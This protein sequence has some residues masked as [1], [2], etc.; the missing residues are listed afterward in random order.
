[1]Q[2]K[3]IHF[4]NSRNSASYRKRKFS[5]DCTPLLC[6]LPIN[7][8]FAFR[9]GEMR[10]F[11]IF[12]LT[13]LF[14]L[15]INFCIPLVPDKIFY[16]CPMSRNERRKY[17]A[18]EYWTRVLLESIPFLLI[19]GLVTYLKI[20]S[21]IQLAISAISFL[22][23]IMIGNLKV[24][25]IQKEKRKAMTYIEG[26]YLGI[27]LTTVVA[28]VCIAWSSPV[29]IG[30]IFLALGLMWLTILVTVPVICK[31]YPRMLRARS[32]YEYSDDIFRKEEKGRRR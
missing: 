22:E 11:F 31:S 6:A 32:E 26:M 5:E 27:Y 29:D 16:L 12:Q 24:L 28:H 2:R 14:V 1:M 9:E 25:K 19:Y 21:V 13:I 7:I 20:T 3:Y 4:Y 23:I 17:I 30:Q 18:K 8:M 15:I 10:G